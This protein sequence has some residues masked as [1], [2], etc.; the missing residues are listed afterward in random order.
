MDFVG[1]L[2]EQQFKLIKHKIVTAPVLIMPDLSKPFQVEADISFR[3]I[4]CVLL[5]EKDG[6]WHPVA[7]ES[8]KLNSAQQHYPTH[9][10]E[11]YALV[12]ALK[13]WRDYLLGN[14]F[15]TKLITNLFAIYLSSLIYQGDKQDGFSCYKNIK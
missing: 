6:V 12:Y 3:A 4:R 13:T 11:L 5:Q 10:C 15:V 7:F 2:S 8:H 9:E 1:L 14:L